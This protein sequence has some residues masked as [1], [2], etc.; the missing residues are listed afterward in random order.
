[1][2]FQS[3]QMDKL[4]FDPPEDVR[5]LYDKIDLEEEWHSKL[6]RRCDEQGVIFFTSPTYLDAVDLLQSLEVPLLSL[7]PRRSARFLSS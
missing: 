1:M 3:L 2:K 7:R 4:Y 6:K 5:E